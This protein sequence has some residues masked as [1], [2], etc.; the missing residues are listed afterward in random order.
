MHTYIKYHRII[1]NVLLVCVCLYVYMCECVY[2]KQD[3]VKMIKNKHKTLCIYLA[4]IRI[5]LPTPH[6]RKVI[7]FRVSK[8]V[9]SRALI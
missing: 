1:Q 8:L 9:W 3:Q 2:T 6:S 7:L 5:D 4:L